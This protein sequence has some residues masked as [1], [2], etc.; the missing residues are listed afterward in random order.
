MK[1]ILVNTGSNFAVMII[2]LVITFIMTPLLVHNLGNYDYGI[3]E[4]LGAVLGYMGLLDM[5]MKPSISRFAAKYHS[6]QSQDKLSVL[7]STS[8]FF[9]ALIGILLFLF[10]LVWSLFMPETISSDV[11]SQAKYSLLLII[12]GAQLLIVFP[13]YVAESFLEGFQ[14]YYLKNN[15]TI[16]N[17]IVGAIVVYVFITPENALILLAAANAIGVS[18]KYIIYTF[19]LTSP[20]FGGLKP[21]LSCTTWASFKETTS[22]G[23]KSLIQG[24]A[25][26]IE[27]GTDTIV[28][29]YFLGPAMVPFYAIPANLINYIRNIGWTLTHAFMPLF[30]A[31]SAQNKTNEIQE[32][33][34]RASRYI[35]GILLPVCVGLTLVGRE[36]IAIW[37]GEEYIENAQIIIILLV[38]STA[39]PF[40][41]PLHSRYLTAIG[42]HGFLAK[43]QSFGALINIIFSILLVNYY[44]I[45]G[46]AFAS[47]MSIVLVVPSILK[48]CCTQ[49]K[50][51]ISRYIKKSILPTVFPTAV[52]WLCVHYFKSYWPLDGY[53]DLV[54]AI[55]LG[56]SIYAL[57]FIACSMSRAEK[58]WFIL[59]L[60]S[61]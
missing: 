34:L 6:E 48:V 33:Y 24:I 38:I 25:S 20:Q 28:I 37:I 21:R 41:N 16:F 50:I 57:I 17:S 47:V 15:I 40:V 52:M 22:F 13:G 58:R 4:I 12:I 44:G 55:L 60:R 31:L 27:I 1:S 49:L 29:G 3:W 9:L 32:I 30:S 18:I 10:F 61:L 14:K 5:G 43:I 26:R 45:I 36:F 42:K 53:F 7:Y 8:W 19:M 56:G 35:V 54:I 51:P 23:I 11:D 39:T 46:V 2:K 59:K